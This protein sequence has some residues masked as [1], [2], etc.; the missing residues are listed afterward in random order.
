M[1]QALIDLMFW[2]FGA[3][4]VVAAWRVF[5]ADSMV[6]AAYWLLLSFA[7]VA[8][9]LL[10]LGA[11]FLGLVLLLMMA[12]EMT[13]MAVFMVMFM[14][15]PAGL[16]PMMMV[17]QHRAAIVTGV[18]S[19]VG[20]GLVAVAGVFPAASVVDAEVATAALG[21]ELLGESMLVFETAGV[22][23]LA[24]MVGTIALA[25]RQGR[26]GDADAG[27]RE[28]VLDPRTASN[29]E[30][31]GSA[32]TAARSADAAEDGPEH[33]HDGGHG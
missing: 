6:R 20:L 17:H 12:G 33:G 23:L 26:Y 10:L 15:N 19:F 3:G 24:T 2:L 32:S 28:P 27:S 25:S 11:E 4:A 1:R 9:V 30:Q 8:G 7:G 18:A 14:M 13:I 16:N 31:A 22:A 5:R 21:R 29:P